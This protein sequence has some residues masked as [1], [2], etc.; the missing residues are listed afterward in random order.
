M[1]KKPNT[2][3]PIRRSIKFDEFG[4]LPGIARKL[5]ADFPN[6]DWPPGARTL[7]TKLGDLD[8]GD[9][10]WWK[11]RPE[12]AARLSELLEID[13]Q[14][15]GVVG[16]QAP[17]F[18]EFA[19]FP[20]MPP[21]DL[22]RHD[23]GEWGRER[24]LESTAAHVSLRL[25]DEWWAPRASQRPPMELHWLCVEDDL[26]RALLVKLLKVRKCFE[27]V[28]V[29]KLAESENR[30]A[31]RVPLVVAIDEAEGADDYAALALR[32][33]GAGLLVIA[34][35][36][37]ATQPSSGSHEFL[38]GWERMGLGEGERLRAFDLSM[39]GGWS[40]VQRWE[41]VRF[42]DWRARQLKWLERHF[43][44]SGK[45]T[46]FTATGLQSW[47]EA[48]DPLQKWF[49]TPSDLLSLCLGFEGEKKLPKASDLNAGNKILQGLQRYLPSHASMQ[50]K[51]IAM[52]RWN[53]KQV[54]WLGALSS[55][56]WERLL[57]P[58]QQNLSEA[59][60]DAVVRGKTKQEREKSAAALRQRLQRVCVDQLCSSGCFRHF[61]G[62]YDFQHRALVHLLVRDALLSSMV[63]GSISDWAWACFDKERRALVD[64]ALDALSEEQMASL[65][66]RISGMDSASADAI[67]AGEALFI[68]LG[69]RIAA[70]QGLSLVS[71]FTPLVSSVVARLELDVAA[72]AI[73]A[74]W[75]RSI[76]LERDRVEWVCACWAWGAMPKPRDVIGQSWLFPGWIE[77]ALPEV[78]YWLS[79]LWPANN[80]RQLDVWWQS[81]FRLTDDLVKE[82]DSPVSP[83]L[84]RILLLAHMTKAARG[85]WPAQAGWWEKLLQAEDGQWMDQMLI[86]RFCDAG[87]RTEVAQ[88]LW[89]AYLQW[90]LK[91]A[92]ENQWMRYVRKARRW[93]LEA[94][95]STF[96]L[97]GLDMPRIK[98]LT[99]CPQT[100]P[101]VMRVPLLMAARDCWS[102]VE[103][104]DA[105]QYL[106]RFGRS[107]ASA[108]PHLLESETLLWAA[109]ALM[110]E[111]GFEDAREKLLQPNG[112][113]AEAWRVLFD[114]VPQ[115]HLSLAMDALALSEHRQVLDDT[116]RQA[117][118]RQNLPDSGELAPRLMAVIH[119][120]PASG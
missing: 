25:L 100:L 56:E 39:P 5:K 9:A 50:L 92:G 35:F 83:D 55:V 23:V 49:E 28:S 106:E 108:L 54:A 80:T 72:W 59:D 44:R 91:A 118:A 65:A 103:F 99:T 78:P 114:A 40:S 13:L 31:S 94:L 88:R 36:M 14:D 84:P 32:P 105:R 42:P 104:A 109:A 10:V 30:L 68:A 75:S 57:P 64:A 62:T 47:L 82:I 18:F 15:L 74:P 29:A 60:L 85:G 2:S 102:E 71:V 110:W 98:Y 12:L 34:P 87:D 6:E 33:D 76:E 24:P 61:A 120:V 113:S 51:N 89:P 4:G 46:L 8:R 26:E 67:G 22:R 11:N 70:G 116:E 101:P 77:G 37:L 21:L 7:E 81:F 53:C 112:L 115:R 48:F 52:A 45:D 95:P 79:E 3:G 93:L 66:S 19:G 111:W 107:I 38:L 27:V 17:H 86:D 63:H 41:W 73:P 119:G 43:E 117:W 20:G 96:A 16:E 97:D 90:E 1:A 69:R 58:A